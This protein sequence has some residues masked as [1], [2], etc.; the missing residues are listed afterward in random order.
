MKPNYAIPPVNRE[1][2]AIF[3]VNARRA[4]FKKSATGDQ[5]FGLKRKEM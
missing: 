3:T 4:A 1:L 2:L 5:R